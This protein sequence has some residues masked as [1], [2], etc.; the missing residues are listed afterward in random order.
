MRYTCIIYLNLYT[1]LPKY[2]AIPKVKFS[3]KGLL[4]IEITCFCLFLRYKPTSTGMSK[5]IDLLIGNVEWG[6]ELVG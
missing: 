6:E 4:S 3:I 5:E 1:Y 2:L